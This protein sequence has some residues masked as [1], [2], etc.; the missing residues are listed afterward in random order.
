M[1]I[2]VSPQQA[3]DATVSVVALSGVGAPVVMALGALKLFVDYL[4]H[5][6]LRK[7]AKLKKH[8]L[9]KVFAGFANFKD[10]CSAKI[11]ELT[12]NIGQVNSVQ[13]TS[14]YGRAIK[15]PYD[16]GNILRFLFDTYSFEGTSFKKTGLKAVFPVFDNRQYFENQILDIQDLRQITGFISV[17]KEFIDA[18]KDNVSDSAFSADLYYLDDFYKRY[19]GFLEE[20][21]KI[22]LIKSIE[23]VQAPAPVQST[24]PDKPEPVQAPAPVQSTV[25]EPVPS[26]PAPIPAPVPAPVSPALAPAPVSPALAPAPVPVQTPVPVKTPVSLDNRKSELLKKLLPVAVA[27]MLML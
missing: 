1:N 8:A 6:K 9:E 7:T 24:V 18:Y 10:F 20:K 27:I 21:H 12:L 19:L 17:I 13:W 15:N 5:E 26:T 11:I 22:A 23:P 3:L 4:A 25:P 16:I 14:P 2:K